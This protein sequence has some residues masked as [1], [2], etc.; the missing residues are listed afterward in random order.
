MKKLKRDNP[1]FAVKLDKIKSELV[2]KLTTPIPS[3]MSA[4]E[5]NCFY[6]GYYHQR[7]DLYTPHTQKEEA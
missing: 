7:Q 2:C 3:R 5:M 1:K 4:D 6:I